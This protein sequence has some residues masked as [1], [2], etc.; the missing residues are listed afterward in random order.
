MWRLGS[1]RCGAKGLITPSKWKTWHIEYIEQN[2]KEPKHVKFRQVNCTT[3][4]ASN[5]VISPRYPFIEAIY[6]GPITPPCGMTQNG[7]PW[8]RLHN[9]TI[10]RVTEQMNWHARTPH[11]FCDPLFSSGLA[12]VPTKFTRVLRRDHLQTT[13]AIVSNSGTSHE[14]HTSSTREYEGDCFEVGSRLETAL[15]PS[16]IAGRAA[17]VR[18]D[19]QGQTVTRDHGGGYRI[20]VIHI[21]HLLRVFFFR[22]QTLFVDSIGDLEQLWITELCWRWPSWCGRCDARSAS[23]RSKTHKDQKWR[24]IGM[25]V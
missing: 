15:G 6:R 12:I 21:Y 16:A 11:P 22:T 8:S 4:W 20:Y 13:M 3:R 7:H 14:Q 2:W 10:V 17:K 18:E 23:K 5:G 1:Q 19:D 25:V 9:S 24:K